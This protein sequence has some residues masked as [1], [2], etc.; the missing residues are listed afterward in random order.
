M[1]NIN[2]KIDD[3]SYVA[4]FFNTNQNT[5]IIEENEN[6]KKFLNLTS[7]YQ[8][9]FISSDY[10][11]IKIDENL[12]LYYFLH[13]IFFPIFCLNSIYKKSK[14]IFKLPQTNNK[15]INET[16]V[17]LLNILK[18]NNIEYI[19]I[20]NDVTHIL[21]NNYIVYS[22]AEMGSKEEIVGHNY[23]LPKQLIQQIHSENENKKCIFLIDRSLYDND[24]KIY[25]NLDKFFNIKKD[26]FNNINFEICDLNNFK[27]LQDYF[28]FIKNVN[29]AVL[30]DKTSLMELL[31]FMPFQSTLII[32]STNLFLL[33]RC[34]TIIEYSPQFKAMMYMLFKKI[35]CSKNIN[36][37]IY[38][39]TS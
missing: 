15:I 7:N 20:E 21:I 37:I 25:E 32:P 36:G 29:V 9:I 2:Y 13:H 12:L 14:F 33:D 38:E 19:L 39:Y 31:F 11:K 3:D 34:T 1:I 6:N 16:F 10:L 17:F 8:K 30:I 28:N 4:E 27:N 23:D 18:E 24:D 35:I 5:I 22:R 26:L